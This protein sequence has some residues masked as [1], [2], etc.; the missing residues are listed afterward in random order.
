MKI[1]LF[2]SFK[3]SP[4]NTADFYVGL[5]DGTCKNCDIL[6]PKTVRPWTIIGEIHDGALKSATD[7]SKV[8]K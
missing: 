1:K 5:M 2:P 7:L 6:G 4:G 3:T 8:L